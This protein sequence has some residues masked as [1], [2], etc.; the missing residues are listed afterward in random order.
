MPVKSSHLRDRPRV[1]LVAPR[2]S[3]R[4]A[5]YIKAAQVLGLRLDIISDGQN[6]LISEV[7]AGLHID[8]SNPQQALQRIKADARQHPVQAVI[9]SDDRSVTLA[10]FI[11]ASLDLPHNSPESAQNTRRKDLSRQV[12]HHAGLPV[13]AFRVVHL[14]PSLTPGGAALAS[15]VY[16]VV[17]KPLSLSA[18]TGVIRANDA[19]ELFAACQRIQPIIAKLGDP[20][21]ASHI[22]VEE[23]IEGTEVA[24]EGLLDQGQ[25]HLLALIDKPEPLVGPYFEESYY[26][27]PSRLDASIQTRVVNRVA[28][29]CRALGIRTGPVHAELRVNASDAWIIEIASRTI[30]GDC[31]RILEF[32]YGLSLETMVLANALG[33]PMP[34]SRN[35][36]AAGVLMIPTPAAGILRRVEGI[37]AA[38][39]VPNIES[40]QL[41]EREGHELVRLPEG[42]SYLG[43]IFAKA[44]TPAAVEQALRLAHSKLNIVVA[45]V[46]KLVE[47]R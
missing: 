26:V 44:D 21:E 39:A 31:A 14:H 23:Y 46:W 8:F 29:G 7:A 22:Q 38:Q 12:L 2:Y 1:L 32:I 28:E 15:L 34:L 19:A 5:A 36:A 30:G 9:A 33:L 43:F 18:S 16:P 37:L 25:F 45:P 17:A 40:V 27:T 13:P 41:A 35:A 10:A 20:F 4:I 24:V 6:S 42:S 11:A 47:V 3:Y